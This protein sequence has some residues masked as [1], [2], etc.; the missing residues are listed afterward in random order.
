MT[1][2]PTQEPMDI[3]DYNNPTVE[4]SVGNVDYLISEIFLQTEL[5]GLPER[6]LGAFKKIVRRQFWDWFNAGLPNPHGLADPSHQARVYHGIEPGHDGR[7][8]VS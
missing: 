1:D 4:I 6:Q 5:L 8:Q 3:K 2:L 7:Q